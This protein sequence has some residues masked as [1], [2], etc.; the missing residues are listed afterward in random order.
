MKE[1]I[2]PHTIANEIC[3]KRTQHSGNFLLIESDSQ[4]RAIERFVDTVKYRII[5]A[6]T[7]D[8]IIN[9]LKLLEKE[10]LQDILT[11]EDI[12]LEKIE[13]LKLE[14]FSDGLSLTE[15]T[16]EFWDYMEDPLWD[17]V[18]LGESGVNDLSIN[19]DQYLVELEREDNQKWTRKSS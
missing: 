14:G 3:M 17:I 12:D 6:Y 8:N 9:V 7:K 15:S 11:I 10:D 2:K 5:I 19:H 18:G 1:Y 4:A 16:P 13:N